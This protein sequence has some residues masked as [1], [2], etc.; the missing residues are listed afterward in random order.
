MT[1][2]DGGPSALACGV[3]QIKGTAGQSSKSDSKPK[4]ESWKFPAI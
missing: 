3:D 1:G 2:G 4:L